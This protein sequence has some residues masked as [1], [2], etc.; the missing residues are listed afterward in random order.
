[1]S[2]I[3]WSQLDD[4]DLTDVQDEDVLVYNSSTEN[5]ETE[6]QTEIEGKPIYRRAFM[7]GGM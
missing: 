2:K 1:M 6:D 3:D 7:L 5:F 4:F